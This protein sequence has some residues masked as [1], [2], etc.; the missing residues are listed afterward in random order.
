MLTHQPTPRDTV[1]TL[2][3]NPDGNQV[4]PNPVPNLPGKIGIGAGVTPLTKFSHENQ[5]SAD[6]GRGMIIGSSQASLMISALKRKQGTDLL[7]APRVTVMDG[8]SAKITVA[9]EFIY[10]V[11]YELPEPPPLPGGEAYAAYGYYFTTT[12]ANL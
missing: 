4:L 1:V 2:P 12:E 6:F 7:S 9:Q 3:L 11:D 10:P 5:G 8:Q